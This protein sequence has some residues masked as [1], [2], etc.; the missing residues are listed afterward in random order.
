MLAL[1][2]DVFAD[3]PSPLVALVLGGGA[4]ALVLWVALVRRLERRLVGRPLRPVGVGRK[5]AMVA[6]ALVASGAAFIGVLLLAA[7]GGQRE[8]GGRN[9]AETRLAEVQCIET[10]P[11]KLRLY[12]VALDREGQRGPTR[13]FDLA[14]ARCAIT[15]EVVH[16]RTAFHA[17]GAGYARVV[18]VAGKPLRD[19]DAAAK[20]SVVELGEDRS[21]AATRG[22]HGP[23]RLMTDVVDGNTAVTAPDPHTRFVLV[24]KPTGFSLV[25]G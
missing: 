4:L 21:Y 23:L 18:R 10:T 20:P 22:A 6:G 12:Y 17:L 5:L 15:G 2:S 8:V 14:G 9:G 7:I 13:V 16:L 25:K 24:W 1:I 19:D 11:G 3:A